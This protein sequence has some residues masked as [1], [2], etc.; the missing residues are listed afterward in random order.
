M[1]ADF[2]TQWLLIPPGLRPPNHYLLLGLP[3]FS[4]S[5][6]EIEEAAN[7]QLERLDRYAL[8]PDA[9]MREA[10]QQMMNDVARAR[11]VLAAPEKRA[12]YDAQLMGLPVAASPLPAPPP[13]SAAPA[14][15]S[16]SD[17][18]TGIRS[19]ALTRLAAH[20]HPAVEPPFRGV[21]QP[22]DAGPAELPALDPPPAAPPAAAPENP[23][24]PPHIFSDSDILHL[25]QGDQQKL[26][27]S[28]NPAA[29]APAT[30]VGHPGRGLAAA[31]SV[32]LLGMVVGLGYIGYKYVTAKP[33]P[34]V[35]TVAEPP[36]GEPDA[37]AVPAPPAASHQP[38]NP[39]LPAPPAVAVAPVK[40]PPRP[41]TA[42]SR[43]PPVLATPTPANPP[44]LP[45]GTPAESE[46][47]FFG[48]RGAPGGTAVA[49]AQPLGPGTSGKT[50]PPAV[51]P[52]PQPPP[53]TAPAPAAPEPQTDIAV[54]PPDAAAQQAGL[55]HVD[56]LY[57][58]DLAQC[59]EPA[60]QVALAA[61]L[62][63]AALQTRDNAAT[64]YALFLRARD[65]AVSAGN[66]EAT[67]AIIEHL[68]QK[69]RI[70]AG[71]LQADAFQT[72]SA[73]AQTPAS[74][75]ALNRSLIPLLDEALQADHYNLARQLAECG[76]SA[77]RTANDT[78]AIRQLVARVLLSRAAAAAYQA[79]KQTPA[80]DPAGNLAAGLLTALWK[81]DWEKGLPLL[82]AGNDA[83]LKQLATKELAGPSTVETQLALADDWWTYAEKQESLARQRL[84]AHAALWYQRAQP[85]VNGLSRDKVDRRLEI[86]ARMGL[87]GASM[88]AA[89]A[90][91]TAGNP[92]AAGKLT[93]ARGE[94]GTV[95]PVALP[96]DP[97]K[98]LAIPEADAQAQAFKQVQDA[99][100]LAPP[101]GET[102]KRRR[103]LLAAWKNAD[104]NGPVSSHGRT[105]QYVSLLETVRLAAEIGDSEFLARAADELGRHFAIDVLD[106]KYQALNHATIPTENARVT[107]CVA[108]AGEWR[109]EALDNRRYP[110]AARFAALADMLARRTTDQNLIDGVQARNHLLSNWAEVQTALTTLDT[111]PEDPDANLRVGRF[112]CSVGNWNEGLPHLAKGADAHVKELAAAELAAPG[113][114][115]QQKDLADG[116]W[117]LEIPDPA[118]RMQVEYH[119]AVWYRKALA[120]LAESARESARTRIE[121][122]RRYRN[123]LPAIG[124]T[125][126]DP[127]LPEAAATPLLALQ[128]GTGRS[129]Y[130]AAF[131]AADKLIVGVSRDGFGVWDGTTGLPAGAPVAAGVP[132]SFNPNRGSF[133][134]G[135]GH[136]AVVLDGKGQ[137][138][139]VWDVAT[140]KQIGVTLA[141]DQM[142]D[143]DLSP[144]S[145]Y[146]VSAHGSTDGMACLWELATGKRRGPDMP[147]RGR[148][149]AVHYSPDGLYVVT[150]SR[151]KTCRIWNAQTGAPVSQLPAEHNDAI[152]V[153]AVFDPTARKVATLF[154]DGPAVVWD[155]GSGQV[156]ATFPT[157]TSGSTL[158]FSPNGQYLA[159][160]GTHRA[161]YS[162]TAAPWGATEVFDIGTGKSISGLL[163]H[164]GVPSWDGT[165]TLSFSHDSRYL[166]T[167][168]HL[169][170]TVR[171]WDLQ[172]NGAL[173]LRPLENPQPFYSA[174]F[175]STGRQV[176][177]AGMDG[178]VRVW[179][180]PS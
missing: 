31:V 179:Q 153:D 37:P 128:S 84:R 5:A 127:R 21:A 95:A 155:P 34:R 134:P 171:V 50:T 100:A 11:M 48:V 52:A 83:A 89:D 9:A 176:V 14:A 57:K 165:A 47:N 150:C 143:A 93:L 32:A 177:T 80:K 22:V 169:S 123:E 131:T 133:L 125:A 149:T 75:R 36:A 110:L 168:N 92:G 97:G 56:D 172:Q 30:A 91:D 60:D 98:L 109:D 29:P 142:V 66:I 163:K 20:H 77:A 33:H 2:Y 25:T 15:D 23:A 42:P 156:L 49:T 59:K 151:D 46:P 27:G 78:R 117:D 43:N 138:L 148:I 87:A 129:V 105:V 132:L 115:A 82:A 51:T 19:S 62:D 55:K 26:A 154:Q 90:A 141:R 17:L 6:R 147:H 28:G 35:H 145:R 120:G 8:H 70:D 16:L 41:D 161:R 39:P 58:D 162:Q 139:S 180:L 106:L 61:K 113:D 157:H 152:P 158:A 40:H 108:A 3:P 88:A 144:D 130:A 73:A 4:A 54:A 140:R 173:A 53:N 38:R 159:I 122:L 116:W 45:N 146:V 79:S 24:A 74:A 13:V 119:A 174:A 135:D 86:V 160:S 81:G 175:D 102:N 85:N 1:A 111:T 69:F 114:A 63:Q 68:D 18:D 121:N 164:D 65:L 101:T 112:L 178:A 72:I 103:L 10:C 44:P 167:S 64:R 12:A 124:A 118:G 99:V 104:T 126:D 136:L 166:V 71:K 170:R 67:V 94:A 7:R 107:P 96:G 137:M 76:L